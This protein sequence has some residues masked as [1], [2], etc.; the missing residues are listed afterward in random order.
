MM[1]L[2]A[3]NWRPVEQPLP[4]GSEY[5]GSWATE[6]RP[7]FFDRT[8]TWPANGTDAFKKGQRQAPVEGI[9]FRF[10]RLW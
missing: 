5:T 2:V 1:N 8:A 9:Q 6:I 7:P 3:Q 4:V 10:E